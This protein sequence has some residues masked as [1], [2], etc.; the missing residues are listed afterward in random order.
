[1]HTVSN[2][3]SVARLVAQA[4][5]IA[6]GVTVTAGLAWG[7]LNAQGCG[8][9]HGNRTAEHY[10]TAKMKMEGIKAATEFKM[11]EQAFLAG[12]LR[13]ALKHV[14]Y[15]LSLNRDV[16]RSHVLRGR[17][18]AEMGNIEGANE[19][20]ALAKAI[21]PKNVDAEYYLGTI[22]ERIER[23][24]KAL[25]HYVA[26]SELDTS[27]PQYAIAAA[28]MM[29]E[30]GKVDEAQAYLNGHSANFDHNAGIRQTL[31]HV[32]MM[33]NKPEEAVT[34]FNEARLLQPDD[35]TITEDLI[36]AQIAT[37]RYAEAE[38]NLNR[39]LLGKDNKDRRDL[40]HMRATCLVLLDRPVEAREILINLTLDQAGASDVEAWAELGQVAYMLRDYPRV[41][42][43]ANRVTALAPSRPDGYVL[44][45]LS[46]RKS[47]D[48]AGAKKSIETAVKIDRTSD[49]LVLLGMI[50]QDLNQNEAA[51]L[52]F[53]E[54]LRVN[55]QDA[56]AGMLLSASEGTFAG[57][58]AE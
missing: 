22:A 10:S 50:Q 45:A 53:A 13:K 47:G 16:A 51:R 43:C 4:V 42:Q 48:L 17:I 6:V 12:D 11:A 1:M 41:K 34:L 20:L 21:D 15:S 32:A 19:C 2:N 40:K 44:K 5:R 35:Q 37:K 23:R 52:S 28:E 14:D 57:V 36:R 39:L 7:F 30:L 31:G 26:A 54:A 18:L 3:R 58:Q 25:E 49:N 38:Y 24:E 27:N 29:I 8:G 55:P 46:Q 56:N 33:Q 9:T